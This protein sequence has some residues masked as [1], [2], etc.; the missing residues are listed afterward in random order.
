MA[1]SMTIEEMRQLHHKA[2]SDAEAKRTELRLVLASRY[3]ELVG[4]SD[5]VIRM[6]KRSEELHQLVHAIPQLIIKLVN[7]SKPSV[8]KESKDSSVAE[9]SATVAIRRD[10]AK[11]PRM[12]HRALDQQDVHKAATALL[13]TLFSL[14]ASLTDKFPLANA[15]GNTVL[16]TNVDLDPLLFAQLKMTYLHVE[17]IPARSLRMAKTILLQAASNA[18]R[19]AA[20]LCTLSSMHVPKPGAVPL[21]DLYFDSKAKLLQSLLKPVDYNQQQP[22]HVSVGTKPTSCPDGQCRND[23]ITNCRN[24][25]VRYHLTSIPNICPA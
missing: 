19:S 2:L 6:R 25:P 9:S 17:T 22:Y 3:R 23:P 24:S 10:L 20:A 15:L 14:I 21:L 5:E 8:A 16:K 12:I 11:L 18:H 1:K 4:S 13:T 7:A